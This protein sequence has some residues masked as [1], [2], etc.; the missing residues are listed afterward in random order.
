MP[1]HRHRRPGLRLVGDG[2]A[3]RLRPIDV[4]YESDCPGIVLLDQ[5]FHI[6]IV[7]RDHDL[8]ACAFAPF[9][10]AVMPMPSLRSGTPTSP[11][12]GRSQ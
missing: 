12:Q 7:K 8:N 2:Q 4:H 6:C 1:R 9:G 3:R 5:A 10:H 11:D